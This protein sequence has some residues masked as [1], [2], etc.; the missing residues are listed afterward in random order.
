MNRQ[1]RAHSRRA[2]PARLMGMLRHPSRRTKV[3][4]HG[5]SVT[6]VRVAPFHAPTNRVRHPCLSARSAEH[7]S[8]GAVLWVSLT[9]SNMPGP[10]LGLSVRNVWIILAHALCT[11]AVW[12]A[13]RRITRGVPL[14]MVSLFTPQR[15]YSRRMSALSPPYSWPLPGY[16]SYGGAVPARLT[17]LCACCEAVHGFEV[18]DPSLRSESARGLVF[19]LRCARRFLRWV[20]GQSSRCGSARAVS[21][22]ARALI[23]LCERSCC[24]VSC[25][26]V[27]RGHVSWGR[28]RPPRCRRGQHGLYLAVARAVRVRCGCGGEGL[29]LPLMSFDGCVADGLVCGRL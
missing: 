4:L 23:T 25:P 11:T 27:W 1:A 26:S 13:R 28:G 8:V 6:R 15:R 5:L 29:A 10:W 12:C 19:A 2:W 22:C 17:A 9:P 3:R 24:L 7:P 20:R 18:R 16:A 14:A 21:S